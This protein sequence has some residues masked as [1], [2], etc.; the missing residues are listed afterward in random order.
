MNESTS[1]S[2]ASNAATGKSIFGLCEG[3]GEK[4]PQTD[5]LQASP[6]NPADPW[7]LSSLEEQWAQ[8]PR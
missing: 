4:K 2:A 3:A 7:L 8:S 5:Q 6:P 1:N